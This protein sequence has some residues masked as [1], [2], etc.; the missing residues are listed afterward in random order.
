M[1]KTFVAAALAGILV[2]VASC[3]GAG[4]SGSSAPSSG[5]GPSGSS[6]PAGGSATSADRDKF[7]GTWT[8]KY[9]C[10]AKTTIDDKM[11]VEAGS[12]SLDVSITIHTNA[13]NPDTVT[14]TLTSATEVNVPEQSMGGVG[15]T[16]KL[17]LTG[18]TLDF[19]ATAMG[20][21][22]G[23]S[24]Y[25][26]ATTATATQSAVPSATPTS[27]QKPLPSCVGEWVRHGKQAGKPYTEHFALNLD[28]TYS[29]E[30]RIDATNAVF[31]SSHGTYTSTA[32][33]L[34][35]TDQNAKTT[36]SPYHLDSSGRLVIDNKPASP[37]TRVH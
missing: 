13:S 16:A 5:S 7:V 27:T 10:D 26:R 21:T 29:I 1:R 9:G 3:G 32:T 6:A 28:G 12:G 35:L 20:M 18:D 4:S 17:K 23:G 36:I 8:G 11:I 24:A 31:A 33:T 2:A 25:T 14:G 15:S 34:T 37:W 30:A 22:C 19:H